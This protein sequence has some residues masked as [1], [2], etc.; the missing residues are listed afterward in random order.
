MDMTVTNI[1]FLLA[2]ACHDI[3]TPVFTS[4]YFNLTRAA[5]LSTT[6]GSVSATPAPSSTGNLTGPSTT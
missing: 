1:V 5:S 2:Y 6:T 4:H 3:G